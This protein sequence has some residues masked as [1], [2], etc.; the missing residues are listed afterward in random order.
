MRRS[1]SC[2]GKPSGPMNSAPFGALLQN[3]PSTPLVPAASTTTVSALFEMPQRMNPVP[4]YT[5]IGWLVGASRITSDDVLLYQVMLASARSLKNPKSAPVSNSLE[6]SGLR[7]SAAF[8][9]LD[10]KPGNPPWEGMNPVP[11]D[12]PP[13]VSELE[14]VC[15]V[16]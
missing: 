16:R 1:G 15:E 11:C 8:T 12:T 7:T 10:A 5:P 2:T 13:I 3:V 6:R 9:K 4:R 14:Y